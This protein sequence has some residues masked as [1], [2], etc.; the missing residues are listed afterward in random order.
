MV[1][2]AVLL[3]FKVA[4]LGL[5]H[6]L[7]PIFKH[8]LQL[9]VGA[10]DGDDLAGDGQDL[11]HLAYRLL[12]GAGHPV[13]RGQNQVAEGLPRQHP[14]GKAV[15]EQ[16]LHDGLRV[17]QGLHTVADVPRRRHTNIPP[18]HA[19]ASPVVGHRDHG[20]EI[21]G[22]FFQSPQ[23]GRK[24]GA[25]ADGDDLGP[26]LPQLG[27][28]DGVQHNKCLL[29]GQDQLRPMSRWL[30]VTGKPCPAT[31]WASA[32]ATATE[33]WC[34]PVQPTAMTREV[35]PSSAYRGSR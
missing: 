19:G 22:V 16:A 23:H 24:A 11:A 10:G 30:S 21:F 35:F 7:G 1:D 13:Q 32:W 18:E 33:R 26:P 4:D 6:H 9:H 14:L 15:G 31:N 12:K 29:L 34:P 8:R 25:A 27:V 17:G 20:G 2:T 5:P 3:F 28:G